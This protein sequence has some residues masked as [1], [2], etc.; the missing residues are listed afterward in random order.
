MVRETQRNRLRVV[1]TLPHPL[2]VS[3]VM[4]LGRG[5]AAFPRIRKHHDTA[6]GGYAGQ[7]LAVGGIHPRITRQH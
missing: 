4:D 2:P 6:K 5:A 7:V 1:R 3:R